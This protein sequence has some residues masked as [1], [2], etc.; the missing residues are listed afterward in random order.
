MP[1]I[2]GLPSGDQRNPQLTDRW[3]SSIFLLDLG[4]PVPETFGA[5]PMRSHPVLSPSMLTTMLRC[6]RQSRAAAATI[7]TSKIFPHEPASR[8]VVMRIQLRAS[9]S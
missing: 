5:G 8:V 2:S 3:V 7:G 9:L 6:S 4:H 1:T